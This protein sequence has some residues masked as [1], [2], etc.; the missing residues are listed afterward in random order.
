[1][2][3]GMS[4]LAAELS[5]IATCLALA[6]CLLGVVTLGEAEE[7]VAGST[8]D[9]S[10]MPDAAWDGADKVDV[11][12]GGDGDLGMSAVKMFGGLLAVLAMVCVA[13]VVVRRLNLHKRV[14][15]SHGGHLEVLE[16][17]GLGGKRAVSLVG[18]GDRVFLV[19]HG[20]QQVSHLATLARSDIGGA[21]DEAAAPTGSAAQTDPAAG[22]PRA[23]AAFQ[24]RLR[25]ALGSAS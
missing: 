21:E 16:T 23:V 13:A 1:M 3:S 9:G 19:G 10:F 18:V 6:A 15:K 5:R 7:D 12:R 22:D 11:N 17:V 20:E 24:D 25:Q 4:T 2:R 14:A 8:T